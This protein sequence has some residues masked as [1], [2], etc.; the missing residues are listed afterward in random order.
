MKKLYLKQ[1]FQI[2]S[3]SMPIHLAN[4]SREKSQLKQN[5]KHTENQHFIFTAN[6]T[7]IFMIFISSAFYFSNV[8]LLICTFD[9]LLLRQT[10]TK[11]QIS[12][13]QTFHDFFTLK[14]ISNSV[15]ISKTNGINSSL[16]RWLNLFVLD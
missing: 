16:D 7:L 13:F 2:E 9:L 12:K 15:S 10:Q 14:T 1:I 11:K 3:P 5:E 8:R 6:Q 4:K